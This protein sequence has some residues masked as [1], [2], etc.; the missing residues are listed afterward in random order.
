MQDS[1]HRLK[2]VVDE[3]HCIKKWGETGFR[4]AWSE[5]GLIRAFV[6][7][8]VPFAAFSATMP[9]DTLE[10]VKK[11]LHI[12]PT[13]HIFINLGNFRPNIV[14][15]VKHISAAGK[16]INE[17][18]EFLP[19]LNPTSTEIPLTIVFVNDRDEGQDVYRWIQEYVPR[20]LLDQ[21]EFYHAL[22][23]IR[24]KSW[25]LHNCQTLERGIYICTEAAA[26]VGA[27]SVF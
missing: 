27:I 11:S 25:Q 13:D 14:W 1:I 22:Q 9:P 10:V 4:K 12:D 8:G 21:V 26:M 16:A 19:P 6:R 23:S 17:I 7:A 24:T 20:H 18:Q 3:A 15:D 5:L 2:V